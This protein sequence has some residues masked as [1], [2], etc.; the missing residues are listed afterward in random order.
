MS[1]QRSFSRPPLFKKVPRTWASA[2]KTVNGAYR[3]RYAPFLIH[4]HPIARIPGPSKEGAK[5]RFQRSKPK[6]A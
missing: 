6:G 5:Y 3:Y 2:R 1:F 4:L